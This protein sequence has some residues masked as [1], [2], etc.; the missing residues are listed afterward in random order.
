M[1]FVFTHGVRA[2]CAFNAADEIGMYIS[3]EM[4]LWLNHD[5]CALETGEDPI[6][7]GYSYAGGH[8]ISQKHTAITLRL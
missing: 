8:S 1:T 4:S 3:V 6:H 7:R 2:E 5:V